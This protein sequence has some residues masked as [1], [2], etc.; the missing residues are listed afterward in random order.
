MRVLIL[1]SQDTELPREIASLITGKSGIS[2]I[3][4]SE[5][6]SELAASVSNHAERLNSRRK[7]QSPMHVVKHE[8]GDRKPLAY[9]SS[10]LMNCDEA[11]FIWDGECQ[12]TKN[13]IAAW[14]GMDRPYTLYRA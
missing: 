12:A 4:V 5:K 13:V 3:R 14:H 1:S 2:E 8:R 7:A 9:L 10:L 6:Q 11:I